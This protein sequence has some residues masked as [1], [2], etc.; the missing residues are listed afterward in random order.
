MSRSRVVISLGAVLVAIVIQTTVFG[1]GGIQ[2]LG[3][4]PALVTLVVI[5]V[6]THIESEYLL[7]I[8]FTGGTLMDLMGSGTLG[9]W[10][11]T[12]T[13]VAYA[14]GR[15]K[16]RFVDGP[17]IIAGVVVGLT[18]LSQFLF[19][20]LATLFGHGTITQPGLLSKILL[21]GVWNLILAVPV[22]WFLGRAFESR[23]RGVGVR[24]A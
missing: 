6:S 4:A 23:Q 18:A 22:F 19:V 3:I 1:S 2:P 21:P 13:V 24:R 5:A 9:L 11:M 15:L 16:R 10:A 8:G 20:L 12:L 14:A 7:L 17:W